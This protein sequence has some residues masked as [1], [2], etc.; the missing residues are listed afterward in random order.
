MKIFH[1]IQKQYGF[2]GIPSS[3]P[4]TRFTERILFGVSSYGCVLVLQFVYMFR[5]VSGFME[6]MEGVSSIFAGTLIFIC[7]AAIVFRKSMLLEAIDNIE[8]LIGTSKAALRHHI[9]MIP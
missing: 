9:C 4:S 1:P 5:V 6:F 2:L 8:I 3:N 7:Y